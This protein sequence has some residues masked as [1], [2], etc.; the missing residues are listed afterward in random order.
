MS[1]KLGDKAIGVHS[2]SLY[3]FPSAFISDTHYFGLELGGDVFKRVCHLMDNTFRQSMDTLSTSSAKKLLQIISQV[4]S[5][6]VQVHVFYNVKNLALSP[7]QP[8]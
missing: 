1:S 7:A 5:S 3:L 8:Y 2:C 6:I 4:H